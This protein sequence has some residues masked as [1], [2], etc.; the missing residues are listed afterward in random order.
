MDNRY[1]GTVVNEMASFFEEQGFKAQEDAFVN[2]K[3]SVKIEYDEARQ[4][5]NLKMAEITENGAGEYAL[6]TSYLF[7]DGQ[8]ERDAESVGID[9][10]DTLKKKLGIKGQKRA[11]FA[12]DLP[13][14][15]K[16]DSITVTTLTSKL[17]AIYPA[18]KDTYKEEVDKKGKYLYLDFMSTYFVPEVRRTL[19][20]GN[21]KTVKKLVDMLIEMFVG[22]DNPTSTAVVVLLAAA[23]GKNEERFTAAVAHMDECTHLITAVNNM[24]PLLGKDKKF[25]KAVKYQD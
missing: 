15:N 17:L 14:A 19:E 1:Y 21:K 8:T 9:F 12:V 25:T 10:V 2:E 20:S 22:G 7:D 18:L 3:Y 5:Y 4:V 11:N 16:G 23:I 6:I 24:I 13:T